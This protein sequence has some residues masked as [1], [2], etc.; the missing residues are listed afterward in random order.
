MNTKAL[1]LIVSMPFAIVAFILAV[2][3]AMKYALELY[4]KFSDVNNDFKG[5]EILWPEIKTRDDAKHV[6]KKCGD[7]ILF[8]G[9]IGVIYI[10]L[11]GLGEH[12]RASSVAGIL[13]IGIGF[14]I[15]KMSRIASVVGLILFLY[16]Q[17]E[18]IITGHVIINI[19]ILITVLL[20]FVNS[21]RATHLYQQL[22]KDVVSSA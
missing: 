11:K 12:I 16:V 14:A 3:I 17:V 2:S 13:F 19:A 1:L 22:E 21:V 4:Q 7:Y 18:N 10:V 15:T 9:C 6:A 20:A 8:V 5:S